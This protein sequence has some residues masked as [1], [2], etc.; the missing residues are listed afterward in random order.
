M[1]HDFQRLI[2]LIITFKSIPTI[3]SLTGHL[4]LMHYDALTEFFFHVVN[5]KNNNFLK[6]MV[7]K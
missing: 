1:R 6:N 3:F 7:K 5:L 2:S 4:L